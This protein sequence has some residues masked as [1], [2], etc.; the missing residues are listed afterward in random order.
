FIDSVRRR[1]RSDV[2]VGSSL[3]GGL[4]SSL[5]VCVIDEIYKSENKKVTTFSARFKDF[6]KDETR[7]QEYVI[8]K[9]KAKPYFVYSESDVLNQELDKIFYHQEEPFGS[10]SILVQYQVFELAKRN[11]VTVLLDGQGAD[12]ILAGYTPYYQTFFNEIR[13]LNGE[14]Y[15]SETSAYINLHESNLINPPQRPKR[16]LRTVL[17]TRAPRLVKVLNK[18]KKEFQVTPT[19]FLTKDFF[20]TYNK[21]P[22]PLFEYDINSLNSHLWAHTS[23]YGLG[24]LLRYADRNSMAHS[25]EVRLPFLSHE[26]VEFLFKMPS[27]YK[28]NSGWTK[29]LM[30]KSFEGLLSDEITWRK[31]KIGYEPPQQKWMSR[32]EI[33]ER[34]VESRRS[35]VGMGILEKRILDEKPMPAAANTQGDQSWE[36][37][38]VSKLY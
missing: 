13:M 12:E 26:L 31:D 9:T 29:Y 33:I 4:D 8:N 19:G 7:Y 17:K 38:M 25:R 15:D 20:R 10:A 1:L 34:I 14:R 24:T 22:A 28:I 16:N 27:D 3:S 6:I 18:I 2:P 36:H 5:I 32:P 37:I 23:S 11:N 35:L 21:F 30:R